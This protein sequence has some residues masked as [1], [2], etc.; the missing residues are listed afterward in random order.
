M[1]E[2][3][4]GFRGDRAN[5]KRNSCCLLCQPTLPPPVPQVL[6]SLLGSAPTAQQQP[7]PALP[8]TPGPLATA[9]AAAAATAPLQALQV[10]VNLAAHPALRPSLAAAGL[11]A[12]LLPFLQRGPSRSQAFELALLA[13]AR[14]VS[15][16]GTR[17]VAAGGAALLHAVT[18][19]LL[20][21]V[22]APLPAGQQSGLGL[23]MVAGGG[24]VG[25]GAAGGGSL[26]LSPAL[27]SEALEV[28]PVG[29]GGH[30]GLL[31]GEGSTRHIEAV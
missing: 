1:Q 9:P 26:L 14:A 17:P 8:L 11:P 22:A 18:A 10:L 28:G 23:G 3:S 30:E 24:G 21:L 5:T 16:P 7:D 12:A 2:H 19:A 15:H 31:P 20:E 13:L 4:T 27:L 6:L 29:L 25:G